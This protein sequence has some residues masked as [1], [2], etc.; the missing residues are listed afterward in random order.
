MAQEEIVRVPTI[1]QA[2]RPYASFIYKLRVSG[3]RRHDEHP[4]SS[5][6]ASPTSFFPP[7]PEGAVL[8]WLLALFFF[9]LLIDI[10]TFNGVYAR[11]GSFW[12]G[13]GPA[14]YWDSL[15]PYN[16][17]L[18]LQRFPHSSQKSVCV[19]VCVRGC[20][21]VRVRV[22]VRVCACARVRGR[23]PTG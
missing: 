13:S 18:R 11:F 17:S 20:V 22:R 21:W 10:G 12:E 19:C 8:R 4:L 1:I 5:P 14:F 7:L 23:R 15:I 3:S 2:L 16:P 6:S 9:A